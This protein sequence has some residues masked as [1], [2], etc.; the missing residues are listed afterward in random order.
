MRRGSRGY[1]EA[2]SDQPV[3]ARF[4]AR[5]GDLLV[6][7]DVILLPDGHE[8]PLSEV[9]AAEARG[10]ELV[11][12][13]DTDHVV[14][15]TKPED[16]EDAHQVITRLLSEASGDEDVTEGLEGSFGGALGGGSPPE[17]GD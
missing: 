12:R 1:P 14:R 2:M 10:E 8:L 6:L 7:P 9:T 4:L 15:L 5:E 11:I 17:T 3:L 16:V 13:G